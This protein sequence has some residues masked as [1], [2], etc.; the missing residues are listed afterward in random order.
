MK[1]LRDLPNRAEQ[2]Q[3]RGLS[4]GFM[5]IK[6]LLPTLLLNPVQKL[7]LQLIAGW[8][9]LLFVRQTLQ[10]GG[11]QALQNKHMRIPIWKNKLQRAYAGIKSMQQ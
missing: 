1:S 4:G 3:N 10:L 9:F 11:A 7:L 8:I 2:H 5:C 6:N